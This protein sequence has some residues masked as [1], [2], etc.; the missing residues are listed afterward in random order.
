MTK[1]KSIHDLAVRS[2]LSFPSNTGLKM[3]FVYVNF[4]DCY[5]NQTKLHNTMEKHATL[6]SSVCV[7]VHLYSGKTIFE[8]SEIRPWEAGIRL[9]LWPFTTIR[10]NRMPVIILV[11]AFF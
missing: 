7:M 3:E 1:E 2:L 8:K 5:F 6:W 10:S 9:L 11:G 4:L